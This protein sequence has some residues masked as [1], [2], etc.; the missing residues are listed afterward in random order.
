[1]RGGIDE[2][3]AAWNGPLRRLVL[4]HFIGA[5]AEWAV[6]I[7]AFVYAFQ[8][9]GAAAT[10]LASIILLAVTVVASPIAGLGVAR[11]QPNLAR[12]I[13]LAAQAIGLLIAGLGALGG[14]SLI[15][16][17]AGSA[18]ALASFRMQRPSQAIL[19]PLLCDR[20]R[21]LTTSNLW[22][23]HSDS[24]AALAGP[25]AATGLMLVGGPGAV[26]LGFGILL[27]LAGGLQLVDHGSGRSSRREII[28][29]PTLSEVV[30]GP[31]R[32]LRA[33]GGLLTLIGLIMFQYGLVGALDILFVVIALETLQLDEAASSLLTTFFG[34]G[35]LG[36]I[37]LS[38]LA[39]RIQRLAAALSA[40]LCVSG[41]IIAVLAALQA[42]SS[43]TLTPLLIGLP[44]LGA[45]RFLVVVISRALLQRSADDDTIGNVFALMEFGSGIGILVGSIVAQVTLA[46][47]GP[48]LTLAVFA[49]AHLATLL[50]SWG[51]VR[52]AESSATVP[53]V[54]M[55]LLRKIP[56]F[57]PLAPI[58]LEIVARQAESVE[59]AAGSTLIQQG[60]RGAHFFAVTDGE[61]HVTVDGEIIRTVGRGDF[62]GE[63]ALL[64]NVARTATVTS[65]GPGS[66]LVIGQEPFLRAVSSHDTTRRAMV[67]WIA[68]MD[69]GDRVVDIPDTPSGSTEVDT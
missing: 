6:Y 3:G 58:A 22:L 28:E 26:L 2:M 59:V 44:A 51:A 11:L 67:N 49:V 29:A 5:S 39:Y 34:L 35:A 8:R 48:P 43:P 30:I 33:R 19:L 15:L 60:E 53:I 25:L 52:I 27:V 18:L 10:G 65:S 61:F 41:L 17:L 47:S 38:A 20:P 46:I 9:G 56:A 13:S 36:A 37:V 31:F 42:T 12:L 23:G 7:G 54:E 63:V 57:A 69:F 21:Q 68:D 1:M 16:V 14:A 40:G 32:Q 24:L 55:S 62:F 45:A 50:G 66:V 4:G 64:A